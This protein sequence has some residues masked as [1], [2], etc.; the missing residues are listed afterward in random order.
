M[1]IAM[2]AECAVPVLKDLSHESTRKLTTPILH[3]KHRKSGIHSDLFHL[4]SDA[5]PS[6][7]VCKANTRYF[8]RF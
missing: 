1:L 4:E 2:I 5:N 7:I 8:G 3:P 6:N